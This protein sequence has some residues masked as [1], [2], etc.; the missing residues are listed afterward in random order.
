MLKLTWVFCTG[1]EWSKTFDYE[2]EVFHFVNTCGLITHPYIEDIFYCRDNGVKM[3][4][5]R[6]K[7][8]L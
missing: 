6:V 5:K 8:T 7:S 2:D 4:M 1:H 3:Y